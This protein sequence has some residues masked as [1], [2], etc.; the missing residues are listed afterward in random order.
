MA[1]GTLGLAAAFLPWALWVVVSDFR[2]VLVLSI[3]FSFLSGH[4]QISLYVSG[5]VVAYIVFQSVRLNKLRHGIFLIMYSILGVCLAAPQILLTLDA[6]QASVRSGSFIKAEIIPWQYLVTLFSP[7]FY[8]NPVTRNDW[9]G[10]YAE[11]ASYIGVIPLVLA[12]FAIGK[13]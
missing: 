5:A 9:F 13:K 6:Y 11:W 12:L 8:G 10:H 2:I 3:L 7:D 4:F 1:Y